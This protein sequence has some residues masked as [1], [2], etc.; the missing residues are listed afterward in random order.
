MLTEMRQ[1]GKDSSFMNKRVYF[2][3]TY[4]KKCQTID[5]RYLSHHQFLGK[6]V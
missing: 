3:Y 4:Y 6:S 1:C 2:D 5:I